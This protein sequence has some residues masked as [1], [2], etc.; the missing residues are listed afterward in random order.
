MRRFLLAALALSVS[1]CDSGT[2][3]PV[4]SAVYVGNQGLFS[5]N[6]GTV[7]RIDPATGAATQDAVPALGGLVQ[8]LTVQGGRLYA[9]LNFNDS[10]S[11]NTGRIDIVDLETG[12]RTR[13][14][15]VGTPRS[16]AIVNGTGYVSN[17]YTFTVTPVY[18][19]TGQTGP[20]I[21]VGDNPEGV[22]AVGNRVHVATWALG[23]G[24]DVRVISAE[25][26]TVVQIIE[27][28]CD[29]PRALLADDDGEV[30]VF[31][32]GRTIYDAEFNVV[33]RTNGQAVVLDGATGA[34]VTRIALDAQL[35]TSALGQDAAF[36]AANDEAYAVVGSGLVRFDTDTN[37]LAGRIEIG[38][39][40]IGAV[41]YD[42]AT[43]RLYLGRLDPTSPYAADGF[44]SVHDRAGVE[45]SRF[46]AGVIPG[47]IAFW[48]DAVRLAAR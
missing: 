2:D 25:N 30:W 7:T 26:N 16:M 11:E 9:L 29:G 48:A 32:T 15:T 10:F 36:S 12:Q 40:D 14:I 23:A 19:A 39:A 8:S 34:I 43:D 24:H 22:A 41:A 27:V 31:C 28:G 47:G 20:T 44:V 42:D 18:L 1:A 45:V 21:Q 37:T 5:D 13:Q 46:A 38:G 3:T 33:G 17:F 4:T 35:G 6:G